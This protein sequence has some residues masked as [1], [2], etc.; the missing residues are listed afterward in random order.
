NTGPRA[1]AANHPRAGPRPQGGPWSTGVAGVGPVAGAVAAG[2]WALP[3]P[4][5]TGDLR[6]RQLSS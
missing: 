6:R 5:L 4:V 3:T 2:A 1:L